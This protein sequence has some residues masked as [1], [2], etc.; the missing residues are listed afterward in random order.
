MEE[1]KKEMTK[2]RQRSS[3]KGAVGETPL[4]LQPLGPSN[5]TTRPLQ[6]SL[7]KAACPG[8]KASSPSPLPL[9]LFFPL[10][11]NLGP[12]P[13]G[14]ILT[15]SLKVQLIMAEKARQGAHGAVGH[16]ASTTRKQREMGAGPQLTSS[17]PYCLRSHTVALWGCVSTLTHTLGECSYFLK[18]SLE[19]PLQTCWEDSLR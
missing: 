18:H 17:F 16:M 11:S 8:K 9:L 2:R 12:K 1:T 13:P 7:K 14:F 3:N 19:N 5:R 4:V 10:W 6:N 15:P